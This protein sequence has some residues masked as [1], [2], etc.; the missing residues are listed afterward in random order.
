MLS[1][2]ALIAG[3]AAAGAAAAIAPA[4]KGRSTRPLAARGARIEKRTLYAGEMEVPLLGPGK[5]A[6]KRF[7]AYNGTPL[8]TW[9]FPKGTVLDVEFENRLPDS[10]TV[11]WHGVRVDNRFD[12]V[13]PLTQQ[14]VPPGEKFHYEV[15]LADPG[16]Y[17]F[18]PHCDESGQ[19]GRGLAALLIVDDEPGSA[20]AF[21]LEQVIVVKDW[22]LGEDGQWL[23]MTTDDGA[24][25]AGTFGTVRATNASVAPARVEAPAHGD[26]R[27]RAIV[28]DNTRVIDFGCDAKDSA[29]IACDGHAIEPVHFD[30]LPD[31]VWRMGPAMRADVHVRMP[32]PG[33]E[34]KV[35]DYRSA[36]P[37][38]L[39]TLVAVDKGKPKL[40]FRPLALPPPD[41][42]QADVRRARK[43]DFTIQT[44]AGAT[45]LAPPLPD[46]DPLA[47]ALVN[48]FCVGGKTFW[49]IN[50]TSWAAGPDLRLPPPLNVLDDGA[51]YVLSISNVTK[52]VHPMHLHGHVFK[53]LSSTKKPNLPQ[54]LAD[55][56]V[57]EPNETL[58][59]A[60][61]ATRGDWV[62]HCHILEHMD[63]GMMG[64]FKIA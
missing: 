37:F 53:V 41:L 60:F 8:E 32:G 25:T 14:V 55:T 46:G 40:P 12:G 17:F 45:I 36:E 39:M 58:D 29:L 7:C 16:L 48:S 31:A 28:A 34:V 23:A 6:T 27:L 24:S 35:Y 20:P 30:A 61:K 13:P 22:R 59:V 57:V 47:K 9:R 11:H 54:V 2:R 43:L 4:A 42:P 44:A 5:P 19:V 33:E 26:V 38:L 56:M 62:F 50:R 63:S 18:H 52:H 1:R 49:A 51:S 64:W 3:A 15:P 10:T 21:D